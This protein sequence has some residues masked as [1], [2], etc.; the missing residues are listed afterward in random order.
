MP[1]VPFVALGTPSASPWWFDDVEMVQAALLNLSSLHHENLVK[2]VYPQLIIPQV[3]AEGLEAKI[4]ER[5]GLQNGAHVAELVRE[6]VRGLDRPFV[7]DAEHS[8]ITR[9]LTPSA[10]DLSAIPT[11]EDRRRRA[12]FDMVGLALFNRESRQVQSAE[13]KQFDH[14]DTEATLRN[15]ALLLQ[16]AETKLVA[17]SARL[18]ST[19]SKYSPIWPQDFDVPSTAEDVAALTQLANMAEIPPTMARA[20]LKAGVKLLDSIERITPEDRKAIL[21]EIEALGGDN[22][23]SNLNAEVGKVPLAV[24]QLALAR[25]RATA[26]GDT[27][28]ASQIGVRIEALLET[29]E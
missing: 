23:G 27:A 17:L 10:A 21:D 14:L 20:V 12:L 24:Q 11:E 9:Y 6:L 8:G 19:F 25:E 4:V 29:L 1:D 2:T 16:D 5:L 28:L 18:D 26:G 15:R 13:S 7:E 22:G 3:M